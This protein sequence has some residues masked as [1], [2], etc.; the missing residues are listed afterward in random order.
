MPLPIEA[1]ERI[2][3]A[4]QKNKIAKNI[5]HGMIA[6]ADELPPS[7]RE[8]FYGAYSGYCHKFDRDFKE[9]VKSFFG[10]KCLGCNKVISDTILSVHHVNYNKH[11]CCDGEH[12]YFVPLCS[13]C[14][15]KTN[16]NRVEWQRKFI[17]II[18]EEY[19]GKCYFTKEEC[20]PK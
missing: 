2:K 10:Y 6:L 5:R 8:K 14:H 12:P 18:Q 16:F 11:A 9:R 7:T 17:K 19:N 4:M 15:G 3:L 20:I 1:K 13:V